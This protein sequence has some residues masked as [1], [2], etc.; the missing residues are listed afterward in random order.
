MHEDTGVLMV[1]KPARQGAL[2]GEQ[3]QPFLHRRGLAGADW[4]AQRLD[5]I[6]NETWLL[7]RPDSD[8]LDDA[9]VLRHYRRTSGDAEVI[10][11]LSALRYLAAQEFPVAG[12]IDGLDGGGFDHVDGR[13]AALFEYAPGTVG[14]SLGDTGSRDLAGGIT[15]AGLL[16]RMHL[17][18]R[19]QTFAGSRAKRGDP[20]ARLTRWVSRDGSDPE[21]LTLPGAADFLT[22][23]SRLI[24]DIRSALN[25][26]SD[27]WVGLVHG[28]V[29]PNNLVLDPSGEVTALLDFD[30]CTYSY[31]L[32]DLCSILWSWGRSSN[33]QIDP[34]RA[35]LLVAAYAKVR[36]L[37]DD[38]HRLLPHMFAAY[39]AA[40]GVGKISW[41]WRGEGRP[42]PVSEST[43]IRGFLEL[44][45]SP[46]LC[47]SLSRTCS[48]TTP[49]PS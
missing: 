48:P 7:T 8:R 42:R 4:W 17:V 35:R 10:F 6:T 23:L 32:Y 14:E 45:G 18:S 26:S 49:P 40:D 46:D 44:V 24:A 43:S 16:A 33:G 38:E 22:R 19:H 15:A 11:E 25:G 9:Y 20:L 2:I 28:D 31:V 47:R 34:H 1:D 41:W 29:A 37:L 3:W 39:M 5:G 36:P 21:F 13:P 27:L 12:V 30:D